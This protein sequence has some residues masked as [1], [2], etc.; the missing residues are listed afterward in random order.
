MSR[1]ETRLNRALIDE[2][3]AYDFYNEF[4]N[5]IDRELDRN[6]DLSEEGIESLL[7]LEKTVKHIRDEERQHLDNLY[8]FWR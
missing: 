2:Q 6:L 4:I 3:K 8:R 5:L 7:E 1:I